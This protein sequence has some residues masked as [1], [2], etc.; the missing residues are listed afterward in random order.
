MKTRKTIDTGLVPSVRNVMQAVRAAR[1]IKPDYNPWKKKPG[2]KTPPV[3]PR[4]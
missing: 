2:N 3:L 4:S 1:E